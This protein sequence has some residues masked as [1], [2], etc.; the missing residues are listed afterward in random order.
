MKI[1]SKTWMTNRKT[2]IMSLGMSLNRMKQR[3]KKLFMKSNK[4]RNRQ[5]KLK[6]KW[7]IYN[8]RH[9]IKMFWQNKRKYKMKK[10][11]SR[12]IKNNHFNYKIQRKKNR[13]FSMIF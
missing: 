7:N 13:T 8:N 5:L 4:L 3:N 11:K 1:N 9:I 6:K 12:W 10:K 2:L